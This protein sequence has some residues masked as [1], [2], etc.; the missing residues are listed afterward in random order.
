MSPLAEQESVGREREASEWR[1]GCQQGPEGSWGG[2][3]QKEDYKVVRGSLSQ[4]QGL[5]G[6]ENLFGGSSKDVGQ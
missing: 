2:W 6:L 3:T 4:G 1:K 5:Q